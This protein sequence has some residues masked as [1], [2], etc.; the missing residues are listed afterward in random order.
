MSAHAP[1]LPEQIARLLE[2]W[3]QVEFTLYRLEPIVADIAARPRAE[4]D[5]LLGWTQRIS[6]TNI[7]IAYRFA[8][9]AGAQLAR[10]DRH[11][12]EA[13]ALHAMDAYDREGLRPA[14]LVIDRVENFARLHH[15]HT[16]GVLLEDIQGVLLTFVRGLSGR[17]LKL[18]EG[19]AVYTDSETLFLPPVISRMASAEDNFRLAKASVAFL[20]AQTRFGGLR[21]DLV[22]CLAAYPDADRARRLLLAL[23]TLRLE[24]CLGR[25]LPGLYRDIQQLKTCLDEA[26]LSDR[27]QPWQRRLALTSARLDNSLQLLPEVYGCAEP[28]DFAYPGELRPEAIANCMATRIEREKILL[29]V[30]LAELADEA[31]PAPIADKTGSPQ[32]E[33]SRSPTEPGDAVDAFEL[34]LDGKPLAPPDDVRQLL[35]SIQLDLGGIP[36]EYL[37]A[38]GDGEYDPS[39]YREQEKNPDD[40]WQGTYHEEG[41]TLYPEWDHGRQHYR[42]NWCVMREKEVPPV[43]DD[44]VPRT[45]QKYGGVVEQ[46]RRTFE[47]MRDE[48]RLFKRQPH[49]DD[50][51]IDALVEAIADARDGSE[52][53]DRLFT[54]NHRDERS[55]AVAFMVDMSGSTKGWINDAERESLILLCEALEALGDRYAIY[56]FSGVTRKRCE[57]YRIKTFDEPYSPEVRARISG[58]RPQEYTRMG[59]AIRHLTSL[60][61]GVEARTKLLVTLSDGKPDDYQDGY[62]GAYGIEDT[63]Q[64]LIEARRRGIHSFCITIDREARD[65]LPHMYGASHYVIIDDVGMLPRKVPDIYRRLTT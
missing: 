21:T 43:H 29:R 18:H 15:E 50:V 27:W 54:R 10:M 48:N 14:L 49:G 36:P 3:L 32:F 41:A 35:T 7:E 47:A 6:T 37:V 59:F 57:L 62:R 39:L 11:L 56:G 65:Y 63:R 24:A 17:A 40:V 64:A 1:L 30:K 58:I 25:E 23:E 9:R 28:P 60:L 26:R 46:L 61:D 51:D 12:L 20:W 4:Q 34:T 22:D 13:W 19:D 42:K 55:I 53:S 45:L 52:M 44:F 16:A 38:A 5:F 8:A 33:L 2:A 31:A